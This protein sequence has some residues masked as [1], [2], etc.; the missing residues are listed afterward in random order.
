MESTHFNA[1]STQVREKAAAATAFQ[2]NFIYLNLFSFYNYSEWGEKV[3]KES[4]AA[5]EDGEEENDGKM[6]RDKFDRKRRR[7]WRTKWVH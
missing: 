6:K 4:A 3:E 7:R 2:V 5:E 1:L